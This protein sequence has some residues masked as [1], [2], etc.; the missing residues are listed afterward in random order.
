MS[1]CRHN[2]NIRQHVFANS[3]FVTNEVNT[4]V[5]LKVQIFWGVD[6]LSTGS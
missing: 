3:L 5:W 1:C 2:H 6:S 4:A